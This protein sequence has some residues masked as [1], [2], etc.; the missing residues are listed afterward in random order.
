M[1]TFNREQRL[2]LIQAIQKSRESRLVAYVTGDRQGAPSAQIA[3]DAVRPMYNHVRALGF[4][5]VPRI[6]LFL[7]SQGGAVDV[8]WRMVTMLREYCQE[9]NVLV[10]YKAHSA[11][12]L[13]A[14]GADQIVM[15]KK[16][17]L[18]PID[19]IL[20]RTERGEQTPGEAMSVE[21]VMAF[22]A[23]L[24][25]RAG[26]GDQAAL[27]SSV[28]I[29]AEKLTPW[30][31]GSIYRTHSHIRL[32][33]RK[34]LT[35]H[36]ETLE[37]RQIDSIVESLAEKTYFHGHAIGREEAAEIGLPISKPGEELEGQMWKLFE[38]YEGLMKLDCPVDA[39]S[40]IPPGE[41]EHEEPV[42][43]ACIESEARLDVFRGSLKFRHV[44][45]MP[46]QLNL[47]LNLGLQLPPGLSPEQLP[48]AAQSIIQDMLQQLQ[49]QIASI[50]QAE[51][52]KQAPIQRTEGG[53]FNASWQDA[54]DEGI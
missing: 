14:L 28:N 1:S 22:I 37:E 20:T 49:G 13:I 31:L 25:E 10:P 27:A 12:T 16:G 17:E 19:P 33:A 36:Q 44:R 51:L 18:G 3:G 8:P 42:I 40:A 38:A 53:L 34:L 54:T 39:Q 29:L 47:N 24:K 26:L 41:D 4:E 45:Q 48:E 5:G 7:Y 32:I 21:D 50:V 6:D 15:G 46:P 23:F 30:V 2:G 52:V 11:A 9:L 43:L 35:S